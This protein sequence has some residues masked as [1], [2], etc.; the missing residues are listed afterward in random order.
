M[1]VLRAIPDTTEGIEGHERVRRWRAYTEATRA[2]AVY[3][4]KP[5]PMPEDHAARMARLHGEADDAFEE[6]GREFGF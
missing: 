6:Y 2:S 1:A 5:M 4:H 3:G